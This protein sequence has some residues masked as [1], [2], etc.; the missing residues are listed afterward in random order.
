MLKRK[1]QFIYVIYKVAAP[2]WAGIGILESWPL[3]SD[4]N[5]QFQLPANTICMK[6]NH[7]RKS[8]KEM[9]ESGVVIRVL[10]TPLGVISTTEREIRT[11]THIIEQL[12]LIYHD[13]RSLAT[14]TDSR[15]TEYLSDKS[16]PAENNNPDVGSCRRLKISAKLDFNFFC[17]L[18]RKQARLD[19]KFT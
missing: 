4:S 5:S 17:F 19:S 7:N 6:V 10:Q 16:L 11:A 18:C 12:K 14:D 1:L 2:F 3:D 8:G 13:P 9:G 15:S